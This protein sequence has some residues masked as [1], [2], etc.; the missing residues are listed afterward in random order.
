MNSPVMRDGLPSQQVTDALTVACSEA[1]LDATGARLL[2]IHSNTV[3]YLPASHAVA[4]INGGADGARR[5]SAS[6]TATEWLARQE[7]PT[8]RPKVNRA[9]VHDRLVISFWEYEETV[10]ASRSL[11][12]LALLLRELHSFRD[13]AFDLPSM[14]SPLHS[15]TRAVDAY[16]GAFDGDDRAWLADEI[17]ACK[18]RWATMRFVLPFGLVHGDA[19]PNNVLYTRRGPLLGDWDHVGYGPREWDLVQALYF[20][21]RFPAPEDNLDEAADA[22][23]WDLRT[24]PSTDDLISVR[25]VSGLG[26]Y[27]RTA[28]V[29]PDARAEL[30]HRIK[31]LRE[32]DITAP[33]NSPSRT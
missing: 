6:L 28:A 20:H 14:P 32:H 25:E 5:V 22:Y 27:I 1:N 29:K 15:V 7:F 8:V 33:W 30:A 26:S 12:A 13:V 18:Q 31:T 24:W 11:V 17:D 23:G 3:F 9:F 19:H 4:R 21:R 2:R 10:E 16:P